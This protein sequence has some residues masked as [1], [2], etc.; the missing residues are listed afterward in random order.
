[1]K[2]A[3]PRLRKSQI[4]PAPKRVGAAGVE[5]SA[6]TLVLF[7]HY[8]SEGCG[9]FLRRGEVPDV[10]A[11][12]SAI[13]QDALTQGI[14]ANQASP[15]QRERSPGL[16]QGNQDIIGRSAGALGLAANVGQLLRF[17]IDV[18]QLYQIDDPIAAG[19]Q[20]SGRGR[21]FVF[22]GRWGARG[23]ERINQ[24]NYKASK[25]KHLCKA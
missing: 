6:A 17:W 2:N 16:G 19:Q 9:G 7:G 21:I 13:L 23:M 14:T 12:P 11:V 18:D 20:A 15:K 10:D 3:G 24:R 25:Q 5:K 8:V 4:L 1:M 22:H